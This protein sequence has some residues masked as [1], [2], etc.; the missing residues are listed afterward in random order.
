MRKTNRQTYTET[1]KDRGR[2]RDRKGTDGQKKDRG[3]KG[4][5][6]NFLFNRI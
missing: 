3:G 2:E 6:E 1:E 5:R 4:A